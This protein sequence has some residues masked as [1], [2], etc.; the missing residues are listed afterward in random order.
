MFRIVRWLSLVGGLGIA[1]ASPALAQIPT[2]H[3]PPK[4]QV[5]CDSSSKDQ[6]GDKTRKYC[7]LT[8]NNL[9]SIGKLMDDSSYPIRYAKLFELDHQGFHLIKPRKADR[10]CGLAPKR[11]AVDGKRIDDLPETEQVVAILYGQRLVWEDQAEWPSCGIA[12]HGTYLNGIEG[13]MAEMI[14]QWEIIKN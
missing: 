10:L 7:W 3:S 8:I 5:G 6:F 1:V 12:P 11:I 13:A 4:W 2:M 14:K 9:S